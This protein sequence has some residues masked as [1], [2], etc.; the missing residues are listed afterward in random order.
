MK[1]EPTVYVVDDDLGILKSMRWLVEAA[2]LLVKTFSSGASF[3]EN[4]DPTCPG[5]LVLDMRMPGMNGLEVQSRLVEHGDLLPIII[6]TGHGDVPLCVKFF[7]SG[8]FDFIE[9][10]ANDEVLLDR[11]TEAIAADAQRRRFRLKSPDVVARMA[12]LT[13]RETE[14]MELV[15]DGKTLKQIAVELEITI[16]TVAKHRAK[17]LDK[18][19]VDNDVELARLALQPT[20]P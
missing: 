3:L 10:P 14:V 8:A 2:G 1:T 9:K 5:C 7:K 16:Q 19:N 13:P 12:T 20:S 6:M 11:I 17:V 18:L 15:V 4:Y